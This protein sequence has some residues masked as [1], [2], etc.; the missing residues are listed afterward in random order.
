MAESG[1]LAPDAR[2]ELLDGQ[3]IDMLPIGPFHGGTVNWLTVTLAKA[4][5]DRWITSPQA[6]LNLETH[7][8]PQP[9]LMLLRP[10]ADY[11]KAALPEPNDVLLLIEVSDS[12]L[13]LDRHDKL[14][15]YAR[16]G[17]RETWVVNVPERVVEVYRS[18]R[19]GS[20]APH[21]RVK[22]GD[23]LSPEAFPDVALDTAAL[24]GD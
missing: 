17:I 14:P 6:A 4:S 21:R 1:V 13:L 11:Y 3:I 5:A 16:A 24:L 20:Y 12:T 7:Y 2:V 10:R 9:D 15:A 23:K 22:P 18:P 8:E 19:N